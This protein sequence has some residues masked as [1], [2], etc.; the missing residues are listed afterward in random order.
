MSDYLT[1]F[2]YFLQWKITSQLETYLH[3]VQRKYGY[4]TLNSL[5]IIS[6][7]LYLSWKINNNK[8]Y[9][10]RP[11]TLKENV[12]VLDHNEGFIYIVHIQFCALANIAH[13][14]LF[15]HS[16]IRSLRTTTIYVRCAQ[17]ERVRSNNNVRY[18]FAMFA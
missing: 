5:L 8:S 2:P 10:N 9:K 7:L 16:N 15:S 14:K 3:H 12:R 6:K 11:H 18:M 1:T 17:Q 4:N 13:L